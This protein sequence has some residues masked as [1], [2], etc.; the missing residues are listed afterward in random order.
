MPLEAVGVLGCVGGSSTPTWCNTGLTGMMVYSAG[1]RY[2]RQLCL[3][4]E[5]V[6]VLTGGVEISTCPCLV[7]RVHAVPLVGMEGVFRVVIQGL[8]QMD[9]SSL[10]GGDS[11]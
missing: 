6:L 2:V 11:F 5:L 3:G 8:T 9:S 1:G 7:K 10:S 4:I